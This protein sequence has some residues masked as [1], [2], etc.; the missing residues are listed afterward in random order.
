MKRQPV[1]LVIDNITNDRESQV[2]ALAYLEARFHIKSMI[3][4][5]SRS[6]DI[7]EELFP[8]H[9]NATYCKALATLNEEEARLIFL[10][11]STPQKRLETFTIEE[12]N[13]LR[14]CLAQ[15]QFSFRN[16]ERQYHPLALQ[17]LSDYYHKHDQLNV[18]TWKEHFGDLDKLR[19]S[20]TPSN[21]FGVLGLQFTT[22][23][24]K[25]KLIFLDLCL[26]IDESLLSM[27]STKGLRWLVDIHEDTLTAVKFQVCK[28]LN[29]S[30]KKVV[31]L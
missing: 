15:C 16:G 19:L 26:Y 5:T 11:R 7:V 22:L 24:L 1:F 9:L 21:I 6:S 3:M 2:E 4:I 29:L 30:T 8:S 20:N 25:E 28:F 14:E 17:A 12:H 13:I 18:L 10:R 31:A 23:A 27:Y